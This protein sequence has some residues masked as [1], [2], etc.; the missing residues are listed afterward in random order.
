MAHPP[1]AFGKQK[2]ALVAFLLNLRLLPHLKNRKEYNTFNQQ[3]KG[4][5]QNMIGLKMRES[6]K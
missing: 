3:G 6:R 1:V 4:E 2:V 5:K